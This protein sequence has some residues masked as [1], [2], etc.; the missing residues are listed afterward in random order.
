M[1][2]RKLTKS[3]INNIHRFASFKNNSF[4]EVESTL[5]F[6][7]CFHFEF[8]KK[9]TRFESQPIGYEYKLGGK[10]RRYTPDFL[11]QFSSGELMY[12]EIK[13]FNKT[14]GEEF[15]GEFQA[16]QLEA[17]HRGIKLGLITDR[18]IRINPLLNNLKILHRYASSD[19]R[20]NQAEEKALSIL[21]R[22]EKLTV[23][24]LIEKVG[25]CYESMFPRIISLISQNVLTTNLGIPL[26]SQTVIWTS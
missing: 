9:I 24:S 19:G 16:K 22:Y 14:V 17:K 25:A 26:N 1:Y 15:L 12:Y 5:E 2:K 3:A 20:K 18:E 10:V 21:R 8:S 11:I 23:A 4:V 13:P 7:A 6:E